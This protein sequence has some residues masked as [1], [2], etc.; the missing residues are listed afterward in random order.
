[1]KAQV[2]DT[3]PMQTATMAQIYAEQ[4]HLQKAACIYRR[5][6]NDTP[7]HAEWQQQLA[8]IEQQMVSPDRLQE[9]RE[10]VGQLL[11]EWVRLQMRYANLKKIQSIVASN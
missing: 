3:I 7:D 1:M 4:G 9:L 5:L 10:T 8:V 11:A 2:T 6:L